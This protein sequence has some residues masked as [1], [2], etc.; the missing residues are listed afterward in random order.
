MKPQSF[1]AAWRILRFA[2]PAVRGCGSPW[3]LL[4]LQRD[5]ES[6]DGQELQEKSCGVRNCVWNVLS[7]EFLNAGISS[8]NKSLLSWVFQLLKTLFSLFCF[9]FGFSNRKRHAFVAVLDDFRNQVSQ[10][11]VQQT[12]SE[13]CIIILIR[14]SLSL[15]KL[16][17]CA[18]MF[19]RVLLEVAGINHHGWD[20]RAARIHG[21][22]CSSVPS[23][24]YGTEWKLLKK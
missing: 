12:P 21:R 7:D 22:N 2:S 16:W 10:Y 23:S 3:V 6:E 20:L 1:S 8:R 11:P 5:K 18:E 15:S 17:N 24:K 14:G 13:K 4:F 9:S 19:S